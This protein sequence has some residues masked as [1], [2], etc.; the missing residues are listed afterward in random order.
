MPTDAVQGLTESAPTVGMA[1]ATSA[2]ASSGTTVPAVIQAENFDAG[3]EG[4]GYHDLTS[5]ISGGQLLR[6]G[7]AVDIL[8]ASGAAYVNDFMTGEWLAYT[9]N[10]PSTGTY[11]IDLN[12]ASV[13]S[14]AAYHVE[15][16]GQN[17]TGKVLAPNTGSYGIF[18][19][20]GLK[21]INLTA[22]K[23]V[24]KVVVDL[25]YFN[26]DAIRI[27]AAS[28]AAPVATPYL[29]TP[30][31]LPSTFEAENFD[32]GG[33]GVAFH[34]LSSGNTGG[35]YRPNEAVDIVASTNASGGFAVTDFQAGEWVAYSVNVATAGNFTTQ[36]HESTTLANAAFHVEI[37]GQNVTGTLGMPN[38]GDISTYRWTA[39]QAVAL[40]AGRHQVKIVSEQGPFNLD[41]V[42]FAP[43]AT[44]QATSS[45]KLLFSTGLEGAISLLPV[46]T[47]DCWSIGCWQ[48]ITG[49]DSVTGFS[50]PSTLGG[51]SNMFLLD[52]DPINPATANLADYV[53]SSIETVA[54]HT[55]ATTRAARQQIS[56]N[57][58]GTEPMGTQ[59]LQNEFMFQPK[60]T[61]ND[62]YVSYW[63]KLQPD[64]VEKMTN[65]PAGAGI[66]RGGTW[67]G[68]FALKTGTRTATGSAQ[69]NGDYRI[70]AYVNT[71]GGGA[72]YW[73][74]LG[75]NNAGS[76]AA[77]V[78]YWKIDNHDIPVPVG[79]WFKLEI[80]WHRSSGSD[81][82][83][84]MGANG[85]TIADY[86]GPN[87][88]ASNLPINRIM[89]PM[90]YSG[91][92]MPAYQ[93]FDDLEIW[94]G[95]PAAGSN[96]P[97]AAH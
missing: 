19:W 39:M 69:N 76:G 84:W 52:S 68:I 67:R 59:G 5:F 72:P 91:Q 20:W 43:A 86:R 56:K 48:K 58:N 57:L 80:Y 82:R 89:A 96:P 70:E 73:C 49:L 7:E 11:N 3:G 4:V 8:G 85:K 2:T 1:A 30:A 54:G 45:A 14:T 92:R 87:M 16:D 21:Q 97:Y 90:L 37:D 28:A 81:G 79:Q 63:L 53:F 26:L 71:Y 32:G 66:D 17:V 47:T 42:I 78:T 51:G 44:T 93:W 74:I 36:M 23:H 27:S 13:F 25:Q 41:S 75:D 64:M 40:T 62:L 61:I 9:I 29:G 12:A 33:E 77:P 6:I 83:V 94:D 10:V 50:L 15:V 38:T 60:D 34:D 22:G 24:L 18:K 31:P 35:A 88:G 55:G 46:V 65:L 95:F